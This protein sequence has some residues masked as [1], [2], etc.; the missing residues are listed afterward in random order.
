MARQ[1]PADGR[2]PPGEEICLGLAVPC[3]IRA[4]KARPDRTLRMSGLTLNLLLT[5]KGGFFM[6]KS[7]FSV[8]TLA[9]MAMLAAVSVVLARLLIPMPNATTRFSIEGA[10]IILA[11]LVLG[12]L[13]GALVGWV[14]DAVGCLFSAYGYNPLFS[15]PPVLMG[16]CAGWMRGWV[17][18]KPSFLRVWLSFLPAV[19]LGSVLWQSYW[20]SFLY[21]SKS[22]GAFLI[23]RSLQ[24]AITSVLN[25]LVVHAVLRSGIMDRFQSR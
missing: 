24:F 19:V 10:P 13:P 9:T 5:M 16:L 23:S 8:R 3:R 15:V 11:G 14:A 1:V 18:A 22:F 21:G 2:L 17:R 12:P 6:R 4:S 25:A 20:L 7:I